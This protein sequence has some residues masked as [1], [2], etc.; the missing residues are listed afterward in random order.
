MGDFNIDYS[1]YSNKKWLH[2]VQLFDLKQMIST[3]TRVTPNTSSIIDHLYCTNTEHI[4]DCFVP[5]YS[6]N[7]HFPICF[8]RK[9]NSKV[10]KSCHI[11]TSY[12]CFKTFD[13][14]LFLRDL[15]EELNRFS[16]SESDIEN[17][18]SLWYNILIKQLDQYAPVKTKQVETKHMPPWFNPEIAQARTNGT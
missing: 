5:H 14:E 15:S 6:I 3:P 16:V 11:S 7:D 10:K 8:T 12:R 17:D 13:E 4:S 1:N 18:L 9:I 2:L